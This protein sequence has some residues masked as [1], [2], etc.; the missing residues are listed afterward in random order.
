MDSTKEPS[1]LPTFQSAKTTHELV[2]ETL[3]ASRSFYHPT[4]RPNSAEPKAVL[5]RAQVVAALKISVYE[6]F[7]AQ[8]FVTLTGGVFLPAFALA[9]GANNFYIGA[10]AAIPFFANLFQLAGAFFVE[11]YGWRKKFCIITSSLQRLSWAPAVILFLL[12]APESK[13]AALGVLLAFM[14][15]THAL[16]AM[17]GV[18]WLSWMTDV[19]PEGIR[20]RYFGL[21]NAVISIATSLSTFAG[22]WFLERQQGRLSAFGI[23]FLI[24]SAAGAVCTVLLIKQPEPPKLRPLGQD[25]FFHLYLE[26]FRQPNFRRLLR[27]SMLWQFGIYFASPFFVVYMLTELGMSYALTAIYAVIAAVFD[28][29]GMRVW[30]HV[31]DHTGNKPVITISAAA[32]ATLPWIWLSTTSN[33]FSFYWLIPLLHIAGGF[34]WAGYNLCSTNIMFRLAPRDRNSIYFGAWAACNGLAACA[35]SLLGGVLGRWAAHHEIQLIFFSLAGLKTVFLL[36]GVLRVAA[37][38]LLRPIREPQGMRTW[39]AIRVLRDV[40]SWPL[41][42]SDHRVFVSENGS[43]QAA[44]ERGPE[45]SLWPLFGRR[46]KP[47]KSGLK[48][49][50]E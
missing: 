25:R 36:A 4:E 28:L 22:G 23:L 38:F 13:S 21:R 27:F 48:K 45:E 40:K 31:S 30:G 26:P 14:I 3:T 9:L 44:P 11:K 24:A 18:A 39:Q 17:A 20:G 2:P 16:A 33:A 7:S 12:F 10:L 1:D 49:K 8:T 42:L 29:V 15:V 19:V 50:Q 46:K 6:G 34:F 41:I 37:V 35:G 32:A 43:T 5:P 47:G